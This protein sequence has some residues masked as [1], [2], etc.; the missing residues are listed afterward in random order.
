MSADES[1]S[2]NVYPFENRS[3]PQP[4]ASTAPADDTSPAGTSSIP[5]SEPSAEPAAPA[6]PRRRWPL[7]SVVGAVLLA[8]AVVLLAVWRPWGREPDRVTRQLGV[9]GYSADVPRDW[10]AWR[11]PGIE[12]QIVLA[13]VDWSG[14][15]LG[16]PGTRREAAGM[17]QQQPE[18]VVGLYVAERPLLN[19]RDPVEQGKQIQA[20]L[21]FSTISAPG[22]QTEL[23]GRDTS[24]F[25]GSLQLA[26]GEV[27]HL[28]VHLMA[29]P[30]PVLLV[31]FA[32]AQVDH[33]WLATFHEV[34]TSIR[35]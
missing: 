28:H 27:L 33:A 8:A 13:P 6:G 26:P 12:G 17:A 5:S 29:G 23:A 15:F 32:P 16:E 25:D 10:E 18:S 30:S 14:I 22:D 34:T 9:G 24:T 2:A 1:S 35:E 11:R 3:A 31:F 4:E 20:S 21:P 7:W 19:A